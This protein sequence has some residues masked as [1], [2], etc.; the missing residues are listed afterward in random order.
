MLGL[1]KEAA[2]GGVMGGLAGTAFY[3]AGKA[4]G[5]LKDSIRDVRGKGGIAPATRPTH[6]QGFSDKG[7]NPKPGERTFD[8]Y[9]NENVPRD[10]ETKLYTN[11]SGFNT[12]P[13]NDG[14]FKRFGTEPNQHG[15]EGPHVHQPTRNI[16]PN[17]GIVTGKPG[18]KT[19]NGGVTVPEAKDIKQ[20]YE[21]LIN[22]KYRK[23]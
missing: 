7:Y 16:N 1:L 12:N 14:H 4:F 22:G 18:S 20:L 21:Y 6:G 8:R 17:N 23:G 5:F 10:V 13:R 19:K 2:V 3:G 11:S 15:I 9:V